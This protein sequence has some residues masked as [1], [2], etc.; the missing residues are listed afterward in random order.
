MS[1]SIKLTLVLA[2]ATSALAAAS[3]ATAET[4]KANPVLLDKSAGSCRASEAGAYTL[5]LHDQALEVDNQN[6]R[7]GET[8]VDTAGAVDYHF[9]SP[10]GASLT[11]SG[12]AQTKDLTISN[13]NFGCYWKLVPKS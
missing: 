11:L 10:S 6:G 5:T 7:Q 2:T 3:P 4:W 12:N 13:T 1:R 9:K 8:H